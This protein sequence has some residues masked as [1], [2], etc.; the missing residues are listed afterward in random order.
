[1]TEPLSRWIALLSASSEGWHVWGR[2]DHE[3]PTYDLWQILLVLCAAVVATALGVVLLRLAG[4]FR[5]NSSRAFF[6]ELCR[7]H[8]LSPSNRRALLRLAAARGLLNPSLLFVE[9]RH[10]ETT[11]L[12]PALQVVEKEL[13]LLRDRLFK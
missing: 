11:D 6:R 10:F 12:P 2:F 9:P 13:Q 8:G 4:R 1:M 7:A 3:R 5:T